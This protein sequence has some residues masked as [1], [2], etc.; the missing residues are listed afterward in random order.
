MNEELRELYQQDQ[1]D[2]RSGRPWSETLER[3]RARR[4]RAEDLLA[5]GTLR[6]AEDY[7]RAAMLFQH[8]ETLE[9][10][11]RAHE[12]AKQ[13]VALGST[14]ARWLVAATYDRWL[15]G[16]GK[17]QRYGTQSHRRSADQPWELWPIDPATTDAERAEWEVKPLAELRSGESS[18]F[19][20]P[21]RTA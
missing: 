10:Y 13:A 9:E 16:Q 12:L 18:W 6:D 1:E 7:C 5:T 20:P 11:W 15:M 2:R 19:R 14:N 17:P 21:G 3:D 8:G 4:R